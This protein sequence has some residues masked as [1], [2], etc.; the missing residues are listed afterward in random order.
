MG[1]G[2]TRFFALRKE[3][4]QNPKA[5]SP[6]YKRATP[7]KLSAAVEAEIEKELLREKELVEDRRLPI[8]SYNYS[9]LRDRLGK[10]GINVSVLQQKDLSGQEHGLLQAPSQEESP[11]PRSADSLHWGL[12]ATRCLPSLLVSLRP[13]EMDFDHLH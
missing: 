10:N 13:G 3:Y 1:I 12:G 9:A 5:F 7:A 11:R 8:S 4:R 2:K 6:S